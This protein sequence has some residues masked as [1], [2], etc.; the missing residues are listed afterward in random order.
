MALAG[1]ARPLDFWPAFIDLL[2]VTLMVFLLVTFVQDL[3]SVRELELFLIRYQQSQFEAVFEQELAAELEAG[4]VSVRPEG[5]ALVVTFS[6]HVLFESG[7]Y[8]LLEV[9]ELLLLRCRD[10]LVGTR[11]TGYELVQVEGHTDDRPLRR[12][13]YPANNWQLSAARAISVVELLAEDS[14]I[15]GTKLSANGYADFRPVADNEDEAGR[16]LN[17]RIEMR[18]F[19]GIQSVDSSSPGEAPASVDPEE[20][21]EGSTSSDEPSAT[22]ASP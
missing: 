22:E 12:A 11:G 4:T 18:I 7:D 21:V 13:A 5:R 6:N 2:A 17:R 19:F 3:L 1:R 20:P 16:A 9:G 14:E 8:R 10:V 15:D